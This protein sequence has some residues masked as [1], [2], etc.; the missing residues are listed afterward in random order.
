M[1][2]QE[3]LVQTGT[4]LTSADIGATDCDQRRCTQR[5]DSAAEQRDDGVDVGADMR[6]PTVSEGRV[7]VSFIHSADKWP[8]NWNTSEKV[9]GGL[10]RTAEHGAVC[11]RRV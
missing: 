6:D 5:A 7:D 4:R 11:A 1:Q 3:R 10:T 9:P 8:R 2:G